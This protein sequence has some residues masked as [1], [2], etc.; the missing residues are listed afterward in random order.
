[1]NPTIAYLISRHPLMGGEFYRGV[2]PAALLN[3][4]FGWGTAVCNR[5]A[6]EE[7]NPGGPLSF[8]TPNDRVITPDL[9]VVRPIREWRQHWTDQA[10]ANGQLVVADIDDD[11]W[12]HDYYGVDTGPVEHES[13]HYD[14]WFWNVDA[15]LVST[16]HL[17]SR[18]KEM[19]HTAPVIVAPNCYDP[20]GLT[21]DPSPGRVIGTRLWLSG[22]MEP[23]LVL[24]DELVRPIL[25][26]LDLTFM[27]LGAEPGHSFTDRGWDES[28]LI[29]RASVPIPAFPLALEGLSIGMI[30][31]GEHPY[32]LA[33]TETHAAELASMGIPLVA[34]SNHSLYKN[35]PGR[36][37]PTPEAV[38]G[39]V[40]LLLNPVA[41]GIESR[42][43][44]LW[45]RRLAA[46]NEA[47][48][49]SAVTRMVERLRREGVV[50]IMA[51]IK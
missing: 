17:A 29:E 41:W 40:E 15:V 14:E 44:R 6:T 13:D 48:H 22:R 34:A 31:M 3:R 23:D 19:G 4:N 42:S 27:H 28:R 20:F 18:I 7:D 26:E 10:H 45:A 21:S 24:Y 46:K 36:V 49:I 35:I 51:G 33:K 50:R 12:V 9:I 8:V 32:N 11:V 47:L 1:M 37:D 43:T 16:K 38:R 39:R 30:C 25:D 2:R 5:M